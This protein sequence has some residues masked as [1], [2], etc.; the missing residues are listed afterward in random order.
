MIGRQY[1]L[2][3]PG[4]EFRCRAGRI[5]AVHEVRVADQQIEL[6]RDG[7]L[8]LIRQSLLIP[9]DH[10]VDP[11]YRTSCRSRFEITA[12]DGE[13]L[14]ERTGHTLVDDLDCFRA[15]TPDNKRPDGSGTLADRFE[16]VLTVD[17]SAVSGETDRVCRVRH[18]LASLDDPLVTPDSRLVQPAV[19][20]VPGLKPLLS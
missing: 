14:S 15:D 6:L 3:E 18:P 20:P 7:G 12:I 4:D 16:A 19:T 17:D 9:A 8:V 2:G 1:S 10:S 13:L 11:G 5:E